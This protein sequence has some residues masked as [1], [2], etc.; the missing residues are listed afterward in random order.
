[1]CLKGQ[2]VPKK[3]TFRYLGSMLQRDQDIDEDVS[4]RIKAGWTKWRQAS[5]VLCDIRVLQ[6]LKGKFYRTAI[7]PAMLYGAE[8][9]ATKRR[10]IQQLSVQRRDTRS[11]WGSS[12]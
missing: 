7:R 8:C 1:M 10:H 5:G 2:K 4:H 11:S 3:D 9:W 6:K 12:N